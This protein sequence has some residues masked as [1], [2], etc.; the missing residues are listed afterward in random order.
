MQ[1]LLVKNLTLNS[2]TLL[3]SIYFSLVLNLPFLQKTYADL[4]KLDNFNW[5]Y[6][7]S[8]PLFLT[9]I[10][11]LFFSL[12]PKQYIY[13]IVV[14]LF[15][16]LSAT[17]CYAIKCYGIIF[18]YGMVENMLETSTSEAFTY[19]NPSSIFYVVLLTLLP[20]FL[21]SKMSKKNQSF[22]ISIMERLKLITVAL[23][24]IF[25]IAASLYSSY[26]S[27]NRNNR[28]LAKY[29]VPFPTLISSYKYVKQNY[30]YEPSVFKI[31]DAEPKLAAFNNED[32]NVIVM[33]VGETA[34][35]KNFSLNGYEKATNE[36]TAKLNIQSFQNMYSCGTATAVSVPCMFSLLTKPEFNKQLA[37]SQQNL[38]DIAKLADVDVLWIDNNEG[39][40]GVCKRV[41]TIDIDK[42]KTNPLCDGDYCFDEIL[43]PQLEQ[44]VTNL[45]HQTTLIV[46]HLMGSHGPTYYRRYPDKFATFL[47][48][49][50]QSDIQNCSSEQLINTYDNTI[51]YSDYV[52]AEV[53]KTLDKLVKTT[54]STENNRINADMLYVSD[55]GESLGEHGLYLHGFPYSIAPSEQT[56]I[57]MLFWS[58]NHINKI[59]G[60]CAQ[61]NSQKTFSHDNIF[62]TMLGLLNIETTSYQAEM[63]IFNLC[64]S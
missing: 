36:Y 13:K 33:I 8:L 11:V 51:H 62:H 60:H 58:N 29:I 14:S 3:I 17:F 55:H 52:I 30:F 48:D 22:K 46:L 23:V 41:Q 42:N 10:F 5:A 37:A 57:P 45:T 32:K 39:C 59:K 16:I 21:L 63:D 38:L 61:A 9:C 26:A 27:V 64:V 44:K 18:D 53:L 40:K 1:K 28:E 2:V 25:I 35:A 47:P 6:L 54:E 31:L 24:I 34:R 43:L 19:L 56:H 12:L 15:I 20:L 50:Q 7:F 49:C 4:A